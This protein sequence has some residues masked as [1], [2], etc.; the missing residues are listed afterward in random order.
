M[1]TA[2]FN[3]WAR[4][5]VIG[6]VP[7][8]AVACAGVNDGANDP[9]A[10][11]NFNTYDSGLTPFPTVPYQQSRVAPNARVL[12]CQNGFQRLYYGLRE[13]REPGWFTV[14]GNGNTVEKCP[15]PQTASRSAQYNRFSVITGI[16]NYIYNGVPA[17]S[18]PCE[19][20]TP[21]YGHTSPNNIWSRPRY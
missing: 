15:T 3:K 2:N 7:L 19:F 12:H 13:V 11:R 8:T 4:I 9:N 21:F 18:V 1:L 5:V 16:C 10:N 6:L 20:T 17:G 14:D